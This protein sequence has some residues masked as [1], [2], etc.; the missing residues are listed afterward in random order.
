[1][2]FRI[3]ELARRTRTNP[4][5]IRY[6]EEIGLLPAPARR[7]GGQ[8]SYGEE[9]ERR[10]TFIRQCREFGFSIE[11]VRSL[12]SLTQRHDRSCIDRKSTRLNS[13]HSCASRMPSS[14]CKKK[15]NKTQPECSLGSRSST[16]PIYRRIIHIPCPLIHN[17]K[18]TINSSLLSPLT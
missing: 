15:K 5:T 16:Q 12:V 7:D 13:S 11:Q 3:G 4:P 8:R 6:Y 18:H 14:A 17:C 1:M 10:L 2:A 9:D